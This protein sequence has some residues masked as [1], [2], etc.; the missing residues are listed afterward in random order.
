MVGALWRG[1][2]PLLSADALMTG[3]FAYRLR[4]CVRIQRSTA[5]RSY[6]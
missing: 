6:R 2:R 1:N 4:A 3:G 5:L